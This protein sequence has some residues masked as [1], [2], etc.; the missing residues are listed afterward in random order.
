MWGTV[1]VVESIE[2]ASKEDGTFVNPIQ[3]GNGVGGKINVEDMMR[4]V[5]SKITRKPTAGWRI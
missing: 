1:V 5:R 4:G 3:H 2:G